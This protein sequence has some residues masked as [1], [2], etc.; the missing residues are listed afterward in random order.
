MNFIVKVNGYAQL[1]RFLF[2]FAGL[3]ACFSSILY[4]L[5]QLS[6]DNTLYS[7]LPLIPFISGYLVWTIKG[8]LPTPSPPRSK[9]A[10]IPL[11]V[12]GTLIGFS[13]FAQGSSIWHL[14]NYLAAMTLAYV[15]LI[16]SF[17]CVF[18][19]IETL[20]SIQFPLA[21]LFCI[22]PLPLFIVDGMEFFLQYTSAE[23]AY[24]FITLLDIPVLRESW[25]LFR[26][27]TITIVVA[28]ECSG[29][30]ASLVLFILS[31]VAAHL[32]LRSQWKKCFLVLFVIPLGIT[33]NALRIATIAALC[34]QI[35]PEMIDS[36][37]H[38]R[39]GPYFFALSMVPFMIVLYL[40]IRSDRRP[41]DMPTHEN[42]SYT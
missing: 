6:L 11:L 5:V 33:R 1:R 7:H 16:V 9:I 18:F 39:G 12:A 23:L 2:A 40:L 35:G 28:S 13:L 27:P 38:R 26:L 14:E 10:L 8:V 30:R 36:S 19:G 3:S 29:I 37:I 42:K 21:F 15:T 25:L 4:Q 41:K 34:T 22:I 20:K 32:F 24:R 17:A 31:L